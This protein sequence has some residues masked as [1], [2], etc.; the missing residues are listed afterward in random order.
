MKTATSITT[1]LLISTFIYAQTETTKIKIYK[2]QIQTYG[3][4]PMIRGLYYDF[5]D[6]TLI[7]INV[8]SKKEIKSQQFQTQKIPVKTVQW[9]KLRPKGRIWSSALVGAVAGGFAGAIIGHNSGDDPPGWISFSAETK[10]GMLGGTF[11]VI[12]G[13]L[14]AA[15]G[16][17][18]E[19]FDIHGKRERVIENYEKLNKYS[20]NKNQTIQKINSQEI[21][22][23]LNL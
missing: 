12:G 19:K 8:W 13:G 17:R 11:F 3:D 23:K 15:F 20:I 10:A 18:S 9:M 4:A 16:A 14:G 7:L 2:A 1:F 21:D 6:S 5:N 22:N